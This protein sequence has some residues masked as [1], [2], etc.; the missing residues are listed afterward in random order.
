[1]QTTEFRT[2]KIIYLVNM[3]EISSTQ[4]VLPNNDPSQIKLITVS[5][6]LSPY[7][8]PLMVCYLEIQLQ[9]ENLKDNIKYRLVCSFNN[10]VTYVT[11][12][13]SS[14]EAPVHK[15]LTRREYWLRRVR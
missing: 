10:L 9:L 3:Y 2:G 5:R 14:S 6:L 11:C 1:M 7:Y 15:F 4:P 13:K 12:N 8:V